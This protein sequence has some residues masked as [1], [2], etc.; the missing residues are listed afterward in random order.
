MCKHLYVH[1]T[2]YIAKRANSYPDGTKLLIGNAVDHMKRD[3]KSPLK[4]GS[5]ED[6]RD[7]SSTFQSLSGATSLL[8]KTDK[9][10]QSSP[11]WTGIAKELN[12]GNVPKRVAMIGNDGRSPREQMLLL[13]MTESN[14]YLE[15]LRTGVKHRFIYRCSHCPAVF[16]KVNTL[17]FHISMHGNEEQNKCKLCSYSTNSAN[18]LM[19]HQ[20]LHNYSSFASVGHSVY[21]HRC[22]RC[23]AAFSKKSRLEKHITL[24]GLDAKWKCDKCDYAVH[25]AA[26]LVK[27]RACHQM[28]PNFK[29]LPLE[30]RDN[31][32]ETT[33]LKQLA[34]NQTQEEVTKSE[35]VNPSIGSGKETTSP[36]S[37]SAQNSE[38]NLTEKEEKV[39]YCCDRCPY[40]HNRKD[41]VQSH[42]KRHDQQI[43]NVRDGKQCK[44]LNAFS[45]NN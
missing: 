19:V 22:N 39:L 16:M 41:A 9:S 5:T 28:N 2:E 38:S 30:N 42:L 43:R 13:E 33:E 3:M 31:H 15:K 44:S 26:T 36:A 25:Y 40:V 12:G 17:T 32:L 21:N 1:T 8:K 10:G 20:Q 23:P 24:H 4:E 18:N 11:P 27:H 6:K 29:A 35:D 37:P 14:A 7:N 34:K 45:L